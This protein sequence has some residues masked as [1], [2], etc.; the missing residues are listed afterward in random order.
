VEYI[1]EY[2]KNTIKVSKMKYYRYKGVGLI[3]LFTFFLS[4]ILAEDIEVSYPGKTLG[5]HSDYYAFAALKTDGSVVTWGNTYK[6]DGAGNSSNV[7]DSLRNGVVK[8]YSTEE[9]FAALKDD[10]SVIT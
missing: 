9:A 10:G 1:H 7:S 2:Y 8:I 5:E 3:C 4:S 6:F